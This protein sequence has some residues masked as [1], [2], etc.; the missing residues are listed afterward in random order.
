MSEANNLVQESQFGSYIIFQP[1]TPKPTAVTQPPTPKP[2][3]VT[4]PPTPKPTVV[5]QPPTPKP[6]AVFQPPTP[7]PTAVTQC[8][9]PSQLEKCEDGSDLVWINVTLARGKQ[10]SNSY[11]DLIEQSGMKTIIVD[12][13][14]DVKEQSIVRE[15]CK[16]RSDCYIFRLSTTG[17]SALVCLDGKEI[18]M[19]E[20][21]VKIGDSCL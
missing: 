13:R 11:W 5:T 17:A 3:V 1:P 14:Y 18:A 15:V 21:E 8:P 16:P 10:P 4:Q 7:T 2:T 12:V 20:W 9:T 19:P 6:T